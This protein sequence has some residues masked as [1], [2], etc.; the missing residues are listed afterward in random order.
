M[1]AKKPISMSGLVQKGQAQPV[2]A[3]RGAA[4]PQGAATVKEADAG[5]KPRVGMKSANGED[6]YK[7][8]TVKLTKVRYEKLK[9]LCLREQKSVQDFLVQAVDAL[10]QS[11]EP[12]K[13]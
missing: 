11:R 9:L 10:L 7:A 5:K 3:A 6:Y 1:S 12:I 8:M 4:K 13:A 2:T